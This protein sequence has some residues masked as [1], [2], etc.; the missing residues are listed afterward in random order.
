VYKI[1]PVLY[2]E[3]KWSNCSENPGYSEKRCLMWPN[4]ILICLK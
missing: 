2:G 1:Y 4:S 3:R